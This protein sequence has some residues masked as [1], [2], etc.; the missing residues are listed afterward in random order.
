M[1]SPGD[2]MFKTGSAKIL[3]TTISQSNIMATDEDAAKDDLNII[4]DGK[5]RNK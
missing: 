2:I 1:N 4:G 3:P 5:T